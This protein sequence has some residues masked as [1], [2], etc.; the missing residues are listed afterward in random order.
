MSPVRSLF[1][2]GKAAWSACIGGGHWVEGAGALGGR[3]GRC[4]GREVVF[5]RLSTGSMTCAPRFGWLALP[6][7]SPIT[8]C[9][10][11][12]RGIG[13]SYCNALNECEYFR[14][15]RVSNGTGAYILGRQSA[16][17]KG[18]EY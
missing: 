9:L 6:L 12:S 18:I 17:N 15:I 4:W 7:C 8:P 14:L 3:G 16:L 5:G 2:E 11:P 10:T 13:A 1:A